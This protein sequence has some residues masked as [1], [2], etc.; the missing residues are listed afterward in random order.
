[1]NDFSPSSPEGIVRDGKVLFFADELACPRTGI[2]RLHPS[3][4]EA[5]VT[6][7]QSFDKTMPLSSCCRSQAH[8]QSIG[9]HPRSLHIADAAMHP[10][11]LG[12]LAVDVIIT[13][14]RKRGWLF[15]VAW[16]LG[17]SI[18]WNAKRGFLHLDRRD[19]I[20]LPQTTFDY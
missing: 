19:F 11:Q 13:D 10:G 17:W 2:I 20:G 1:M 9:G 12:T 3:F 7:R 4:E 18:G 16:N 15:S 8:N 6:L 5:L 14:G